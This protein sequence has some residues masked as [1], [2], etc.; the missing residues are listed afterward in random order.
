MLESLATF[1]SEVI[2]KILGFL[3]DSPFQYLSQTAFVYKY[4]QYINWVIPV[5]FILSTLQAWLVAYSLYLLYSVIL[6]TVNAIG[7]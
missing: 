7:G 6:R 5:D 2:D 1:F 4:L 3:P